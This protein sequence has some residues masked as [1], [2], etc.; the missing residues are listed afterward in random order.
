MK[1]YGQEQ[2]EKT[3]IK[4]QNKIKPEPCVKRNNLKLNYK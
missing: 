2:E 4:Y 1:K 3:R